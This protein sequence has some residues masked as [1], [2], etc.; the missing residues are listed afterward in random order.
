MTKAPKHTTRI[1]RLNL[2]AGGIRTL[3]TNGGAWTLLDGQLMRSAEAAQ[4]LREAR[5][6]GVQIAREA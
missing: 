2:G 6:E 3:E 1:Y 5:A 4:F